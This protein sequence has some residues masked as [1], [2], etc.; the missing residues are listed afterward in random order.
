MA[1]SKFYKVKILLKEDARCLPCSREEEKL[2]SSKLG[3]LSNLM[4]SV[5]KRYDA[6]IYVMYKG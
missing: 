3:V 4:G 2:A 5:P 1:S 6:L